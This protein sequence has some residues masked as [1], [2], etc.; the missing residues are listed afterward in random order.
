[1]TIYIDLKAYLN[2][3]VVTERLRPE[4]KRREVPSLAELAKVVGMHRI[5][6]LRIANN[7]VSKLDLEKAGAIIKEMRRRGFPMEVGDLLK[8]QDTGD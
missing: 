8:F 3:L 2:N 6:F 1:M 4:S 5:S 7:Q